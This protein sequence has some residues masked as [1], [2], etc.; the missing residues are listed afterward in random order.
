MK[1]KPRGFIALISVLML[2]VILLAGVVS[3]AQYGITSRYALLALEKKE[4]SQSLAEA[5]LQ[6]ARIAIVND[7]SYVVTNKQVAIDSAWCTIVSID[8]SGSNSVV[9]ASASSSKATTNLRAEINKTSGVI[10]RIEEK[11]TF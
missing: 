2:S 1:K 3:L 6:V 9:K 7:P 8:A 11:V 4:I 5:C 10:I